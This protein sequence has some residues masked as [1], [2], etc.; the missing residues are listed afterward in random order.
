M[1]VSEPLTELDVDYSDLVE[2]IPEPT[3][4]RDGYE[5]RQDYER[6][7]VRLVKDCYQESYEKYSK[8]KMKWKR[9]DKLVELEHVLNYAAN[10]DPSETRLPTLIEAIEE[11]MSSRLDESLIPAIESRQAAMDPLVE[12]LNYYMGEVLDANRYQFLKLRLRFDQLRYRIGFFYFGVD[13]RSEGLFGHKGKH[14]IDRID[15]RCV[16]PDAYAKDWRFDNMRYLIIA[17][18]MDLTEVVRTWPSSAGRIVRDPN[19]SGAARATSEDEADSNTGSSIKFQGNTA[20]GYTIGQRDRCVVY[21]CYLRDGRVRKI[22][23][24]NQYDGM[25]LLNDDGE[26]ICEYVDLYPKGRK[27]VTCGNILLED[28]PNPYDHGLPPLVAYPESPYEGMFSF[29]PVE[30]LD[31]ADRKVNKLAKEMFSN[32]CVNMNSPLLLSNKAFLK[33]SQYDNVKVKAGQMWVVRDNTTVRRLEP[34]IIP[35]ETLQIISFFQKAGDAVLG[36]TAISR[37]SLEGAPE[38]SS[39]T[40]Q[41]LQ[42]SN[43]KRGKLKSEM[44]KEAMQQA[45]LILASNIRQFTPGTLSITVKD[46]A[47]G[48]DKVLEWDSDKW[49]DKWVM[50]VTVSSSSPGAKQSFEQQSL[51]LFKEGVVDAQYVRDNLKVPPP[52]SQRIEQRRDEL[53]EKGLTAEALQYP[54][55]KKTP[56]R[57]SQ[58]PLV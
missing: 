27:I 19:M 5:S 16:W 43:A 28:R 53:A 47:T 12:T 9:A 32:L 21:E 55:I 3:W 34:G 48:N 29:S 13:A 44:D 11:Y 7:L 22:P 50:K 37:G 17:R 40:V 31:I 20:A 52:I 4:K 26:E 54:K 15:P 6:A 41:D 56:G 39:Q 30:A 58:Q 51:V 23:Q 24:V 38:I 10:S 1:A 42:G 57:R 2:A 35:P 18:V 45:G 8:E 14:I 49:D 25:P 46:S 36:T 33:Q